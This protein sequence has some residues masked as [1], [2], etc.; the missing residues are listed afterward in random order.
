MATALKTSNSKHAST[1]KPALPSKAPR[2]TTRSR[3]T[4]QERHLSGVSFEFSLDYRIKG[5]SV[6][7]L[8]RL[9]YSSDEIVEGSLR[10]IAES[11]FEQLSRLVDK[12][13]NAEGSNSLE[14]I[15]L[16][17]QTKSGSTLVVRGYLSRQDTKNKA[18]QLLRFEGVDISDYVKS[19][20]LGAQMH[21]IVENAPINIMLANLDGTI[22]Y[23]N[24]AS[25]K[26]LQSIEH[27]LPIKAD[28]I[29]GKSFDIFHKNPSHQRR[30][31]ADPKN[32]P[33]H[34]EFPLGNE[35]LS[36]TAAAIYT[37]DGNYAGPMVAWEVITDRRNAQ[38]REQE[39]QAAERAQQ[40]T[41]RQHVAQLLDVVNRAASGDLTVTAN[42]DAEGSIAEL[43]QGLNQ[44]IIDL[45]EIIS[46]VVEGAAQFSEG[47]RVVAESAQSL[48]EGAQTQSASVQQM[49]ASID[50]LARSIDA[51]KENAVTAND[52]AKETSN[53]AFQGGSAVKKSIEAMEKIKASST[54]I[55]EIIQVISE[56]ASQTNLLALN[57]AIEAARAGEHGLGFAVVADEVRKLA[58][59]S[60]EAAKEISGLIRESTERVEEGGRLSEQTGDSL[61]RIIQGVE[62]TAKQIAEIANS[63]ME[64]AHNASEVSVAIQ[65]IS[66]ITEQSAA[67]SEQMASSSEELGAQANALRELV[68]RFRT[69]C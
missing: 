38:K 18:E 23:I 10:D 64:Q 19:S 60:S 42:L 25:R 55:S 52:V 22:V 44:M 17:L 67:G 24:P 26:T 41:L 53:L 43:S 46:Q 30:L 56:I 7:L 45:R 2:G 54:Q 61:Q 33:H 15:D 40:E 49:S 50:E 21:A 57:A 8:E 31:L 1:V 36:L 9:G 5:V 11:G 14:S 16:R 34:T 27:L 62:T 65:Q 59:R 20:D 58:E 48:A 39:Q 4:E 12:S 32:L 69:E 29:V 6:C 51:V 35:V 63:T 68:S 13:V 47:S 37:P 66:S 3:R 28:A